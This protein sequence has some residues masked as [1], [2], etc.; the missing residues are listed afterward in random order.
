MFSAS[1]WVC[2]GMLGKA[3]SL[4]RFELKIMV[5]S[6]GDALLSNF[7]KGVNLLYLWLKFMGVFIT[8]LYYSRLIRSLC[9]NKLLIP[10]HLHLS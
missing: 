2:S 8:G 9:L 6:L 5:K 1:L 3:L 7:L 4:V 10:T